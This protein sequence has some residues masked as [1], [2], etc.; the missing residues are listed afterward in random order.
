MINIDTLKFFE[1]LVGME[2]GGVL[3]KV[4]DSPTSGRASV[5]EIGAGWGGDFVI[6]SKYSFQ[7]R[8]T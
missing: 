8:H 5:F 3:N 7:I 4:F 6:R 2:R 1:A